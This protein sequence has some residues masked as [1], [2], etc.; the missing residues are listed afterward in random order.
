M[1]MA[2]SVYNRRL[3]S[4]ISD[5]IRMPVCCSIAHWI[6]TTRSLKERLFRFIVNVFSLCFERT[7]KSFPKQIRSILRIVTW[8][9]EKREKTTNFDRFIF[10]FT[11]KHFF[12]EKN[13]TDVIKGGSISPTS[14]LKAFGSVDIH[15]FLA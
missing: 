6:E 4:S 12:T 15:F 5:L 13:E 7:E 11:R 3:N 9:K 8:S 1:W 2:I 10:S 14:Y